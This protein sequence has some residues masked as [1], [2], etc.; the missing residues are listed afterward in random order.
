MPEE[1]QRN[2]VGRPSKLTPE[3]VERICRCL[4]RGSYIETA[5]EANGI[6]RQTF[7][8]WCKLARSNDPKDAIY[9]DFF[10]LVSQAMAEGEMRDTDL[11]DDMIHGRPEVVD[12]DT[13]EVAIKAIPPHPGLLTWRLE[14]R[15][16]AHWGRSDRLAMSVDVDAKVD[17]V[18]RVEGMTT[19]ERQLRIAELNAKLLPPKDESK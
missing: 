14:R 8:N 16:P 7:L 2:P 11:L 12:A 4:R 10:E 18:A 13:G 9:K 3:I 6:T 1:L 19:E 15:H 5:V 17:V